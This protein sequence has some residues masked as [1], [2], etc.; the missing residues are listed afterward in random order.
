VKLSILYGKEKTNISG[1][2]GVYVC[3]VCV[4]NVL[5]CGVMEDYKLKEINAPLT[6]LLGWSWSV[7]LCVCVCLCELNVSKSN[8]LKRSSIQLLYFLSTNVLPVVP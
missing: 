7:T 4:C 5:E 2:V 6:H 1:W 8:L 3:V